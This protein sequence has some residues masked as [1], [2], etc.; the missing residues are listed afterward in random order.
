MFC[1]YG[2]LYS[3][4]AGVKQM[5][6]G[7][8]CDA[9]SDGCEAGAT[10][11]GS[12]EERG[13]GQAGGVEFSENGETRVV[14]AGGQKEGPLLSPTLLCGSGSALFDPLVNEIFWKDPFAGHS[15]A[16]DLPR[17]DQIVDLLLVDSEI[18]C[19]LFGVHQLAHLPLLGYPQIYSSIWEYSQ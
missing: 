6:E 15:G 16:R 9:V 10:A 4:V 18:G 7:K 5:G 19:Y 1:K 13:Q 3:P 17:L 14:T 8:I 12:E 2:R 11:N